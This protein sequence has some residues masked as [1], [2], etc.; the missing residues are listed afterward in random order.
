MKTSARLAFV[1][2]R[3]TFLRAALLALM[4]AGG[5]VR[6]QAQDSIECTEDDLRAKA[7]SGGDY[8]F[9]DDCSITIAN[10]PIIISADTTID[11]QGNNVTLSGNGLNNL[12]VVTS[13]TLI[14]TGITLQDGQSTNGG[15]IY[16]EEGGIVELTDCIFSNNAAIGTNGI[17][18]ATNSGSGSLIGKN[19]GQGTSA[20]DARGGA[21]Y[22]LGDLTVSTCQFFTNRAEGGTGGSGGSGEAAADRGGNGGKGGNGGAAYGGAIYNEGFSLVIED[23]TFDGNVVTGGAA[24]TGGTGGSGLVNGFD[25]AGGVAGDAAGAGIYSTDAADTTISG[26]TRRRQRGW[27]RRNFRHGR[28]S[29]RRCFRRRSF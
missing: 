1:P 17:S 21:I 8:V 20:D 18:A 6:L 29:G 15:A 26:S 7:E 28:K 23:S 5:L 2:R 11:A 13:G 12:F 3:K 9:D 10:G 19:G 14:L 4:F 24:G 16:I 27:R 22:N 25:G